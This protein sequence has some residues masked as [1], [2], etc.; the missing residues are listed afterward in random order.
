MATY[1]WGAR[2]HRG[3]KL[4]GRSNDRLKSIKKRDLAN[5]ACKGQHF[6]IIFKII[7]YTESKANF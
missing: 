3:G 7:A 4:K 2:V 1:E 6:K 5:S